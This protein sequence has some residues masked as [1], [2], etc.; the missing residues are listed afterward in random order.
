MSEVLALVARSGVRFRVAPEG[1]VIGRGA[2]CELVI[3]DPSVSRV[4]AIVYAE[5]DGVTLAVV[6]SAA[7]LVNGKPASATQ[8]VAIGDTISV[9]GHEYGVVVEPGTSAVSAAWMLRDREGQLY[10]VSRG[11]VVLGG[12]ERAAVRV[13]GWPE[14]VATLHPGAQ[15]SV[16]AHYEL[17]LGGVLVGAGE[18]AIAEIG[19]ELVHG[20]RGFRVLAGGASH[21]VATAP[22]R[23]PPDHAV[24]E[25][26]PRGGRLVVGWAGRE[27][28]V[29]LP[30]RRCELVALLLQPPAPYRAGDLVP[31]EL[32]LAR[33]GCERVQLNVLV[34]RARRDLVGAGLDGVTLI[35]RARGGVATK[36]VIDPDARVAVL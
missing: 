27:T 18:L 1:L 28:A 8:I 35:E 4:Q 2:R 6:G 31:D 10:G 30:E 16:E 20:D 3:D 33:L 17:E 36:F 11:A 19:Q 26:L 34:H 23:V 22:R 21:S 13:P 29:Y 5:G 32:V 7:T 25:L 24:L 14:R 9:A 12:G 15:L